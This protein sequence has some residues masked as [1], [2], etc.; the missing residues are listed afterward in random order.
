[1]I[2]PVGPDGGS[3]RLSL[4]PLPYSFASHPRLT[5]L[6]YF[7]TTVP[8]FAQPLPSLPHSNRPYYTGFRASSLSSRLTDAKQV[9]WQVDKDSQGKVTQKKL[10]GVR[11]VPLVRPPT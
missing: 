9:L 6:Y 2:I 7:T 1:M 5:P 10:M 3:V 8:T 11:Y 4:H